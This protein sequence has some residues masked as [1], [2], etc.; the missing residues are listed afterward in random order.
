MGPFVE[1]QKPY[2]LNPS[3]MKATASIAVA[4][5]ISWFTP[6]RLVLGTSSVISV[7][8][9]RMRVARFCRGMCIAE[10]LEQKPC[11]FSNREAEFLRIC[12]TH[13][14]YL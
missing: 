10:Y 2:W 9:L 3:Q 13:R 6:N 5:G 11:H 1:C 7:L 4:M 8:R 12:F 14:F